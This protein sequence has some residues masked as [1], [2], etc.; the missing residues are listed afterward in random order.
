MNRHPLIVARRDV[1]RHVGPRPGVQAAATQVMLEGAWAVRAARKSAAE[2]AVAA[3]ASDFLR[4]MGVDVRDDAKHEL[5][6]EIGSTPRGFRIAASDTRLEVHAADANALWAGWVYVENYMRTAGA[7]V[8]PRVEV[9]R[10]PAWA[11]QIAPPTWGANYAVPDLSREYLDDDT[12]RSLA[13]SGANGMFVYGDFLLY[14]SGTRLAELNH[15]EADKHIATLREASERAAAYGVTLYY[16]P[17]SPKLAADHPLFE[18]RPNVR[19]ARLFK[20]ADQPPPALHCLC[21]SD[22]EALGFHAD[23]FSN[24]FK[25]VPALGGVILIIGGESYY[26]CFMRAGGS[27]IGHTNCPKC[28]GK[29]AEDVIASLVKT[30]ADAVR[31]VNPAADVAAWP[32]SAHAFWSREPNQ[33]DFIDRLPE[34]VA[35][36]TEIDKEQ[37]VQRGGLEKY[38]WDYSVDYDGHSD[39]I[40]SQ[41]L[42]CTQRGR[43]LFIKTETSHGIELL[44]MPYSP[45][46][47]RSA[48]QWQNVRALR[49]RGVLQRWGF[50]GMF[51][52]AAERVA[53]LARWEE[54]FQVAGATLAVARQLVGAT[55]AAEQLVAAWKHFD[56]AVHHIPV[57]TTGA[58]YCG[59]A[60]LGPCHPLP[61]W[62]A[63]GT[64]PEAFKG[65]LYYL[66]EHEPSLNDART[67][68]KD[69]LTFT[70]THQL[71]GAPVIPVEAEFSL[72]RDAAARGYELLR[73]IKTD[74]LPEGAAA[75]IAEQVAMGE[76]LYRTFRATVNSIRFVRLVEEAKGER[77]KIRAKLVEIA[78]DELEN[79]RAAKAMYERMPWLNH[80]LRLDV[81]MP[82]SL[83]MLREKVRL[84]EAFLGREKT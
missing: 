42:R 40:V 59:P 81:G 44:H 76:L 19:G 46:I 74:E 58:Y 45:A 56:E 15:A 38:I 80:E 2:V 10:E 52:S 65:N 43:E 83:A 67:R 3:D 68:Q 8:V 37:R 64:V 49:P 14:A 50:I 34:G 47:G 39:R 75:E 26:H 78:A 60:F 6:L 20:G 17:V 54:D 13:H 24:L 57:M 22:A 33:F 5:L 69:D 23:V 1:H 84:L 51:D 61:V 7:P 82:S 70:A 66:L 29:V 18:R 12:F 77:E 73:A 27:A 16:V 4:K 55:P 31:S 36:Q 35:L 63:K 28:E 30:T 48:R 62:D 72:A 71:G 25:H 53:F 32:Y 41:S 9:R 21:A 11:V 79:A